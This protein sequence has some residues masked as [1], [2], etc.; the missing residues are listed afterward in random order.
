MAEELDIRSVWKKSKEQMDASSFQINMLERKGTRTTLYWIR[1]ILLIE[2]WFSIVCVP[3]L[4]WHLRDRNESTEFI[5]FY[6]VVTV[7]YL[8]YYQFLIKKIKG[9]NYDGNVLDSLKKVYGYLRFYLLHYK[10][11]I[12]LSM[13]VGLIYGFVAEENHQN[14]QKIDS[15]EGWIFAIGFSVILTGIIGGI[16]HWLIHMIYGRKIKRLKHMIRDLSTED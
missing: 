2:F 5:I 8:F 9:F 4:I 11:V 1:T 15:L 16:M 14:L 3:L 13:T 10:V 7:I 12:W 6:L